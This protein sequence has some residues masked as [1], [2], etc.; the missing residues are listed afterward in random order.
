M[1]TT[2]AHDLSG[3]RVLIVEDE[4]VAAEA[5]TDA[6]RAGGGR[7]VGPVGSLEEALAL[8][9]GDEAPDA[10][11][12]D[13]NLAGDTVFPVAR[14]LRRHAIPIVFVTGYDAWVVP[15]EYEDVP[16]CRLP[17]DPDNVVRL[18]FERP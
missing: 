11:I 5:L 16:V 6:V 3:Q 15:Q 18:L 7:V 12:L 14:A 1:F 17:A 4:R 8:L 9:A 10:A 2:S 13:V